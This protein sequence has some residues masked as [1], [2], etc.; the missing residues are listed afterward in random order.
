MLSGRRHSQQAVL[1]AFCFV[2]LVQ[3]LAQL[4]IARMTAIFPMGC[5]VGTETEVQVHGA[6]LDGALG[7]RFSHPGITAEAIK[8]GKSRF[9]VRVAADVPV[10]VYEA[11]FAGA[12][13]LSNPRLFV[14]GSFF[15]STSSGNNTSREKAFA[16]RGNTVVN[17]IAVSRQSVWFK[18][19][20]MKGQRLLLRASAAVLDSRLNPVMLLRDNSGERLVFFLP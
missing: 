3:A 12:L 2:A 18:V 11:R 16:L 8:D 7:L 14:V 15:E 9:K 13:G 17:G 5:Q 6:D 1:V 10:G 19:A 20:A 4:P